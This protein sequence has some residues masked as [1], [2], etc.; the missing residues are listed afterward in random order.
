MPPQNRASVLD[1]DYDDQISQL[2]RPIKIEADG[3]EPCECGIGVNGES[4]DEGCDVECLNTAYNDLDGPYCTAAA[5]PQR[6]WASD[7]KGS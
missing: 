7:A 4:H 6:C 3:I 1:I 2:N 5:S